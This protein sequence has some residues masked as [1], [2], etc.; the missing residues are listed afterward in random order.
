[1]MDKPTLRTLHGVYTAPVRLDRGL[2]PE[3]GGRFDQRPDA[4][5]RRGRGPVRAAGRALMGLFLALAAA[6]SPV[7]FWRARRSEPPVA[8]A[9]D[10]API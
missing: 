10:R 2:V 4:P 3:E 7:R 6:F 9:R 8:R 1:M 5:A